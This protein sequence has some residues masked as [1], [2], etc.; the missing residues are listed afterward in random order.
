M[1][2]TIRREGN[3]SRLLSNLALAVCLSALSSCSHTESGL[4]TD[5]SASSEANQ[6]GSHSSKAATSSR[7]DS[8]RESTTATPS[9]DSPAS[10]TSARTTSSS[11]DIFE[12]RILPIFHAQRPSSC[13]ECHL[14]GVDLKNYIHPDQEKTFAALVTAGLIDVEKPNESKI[15]TFISRKPEKPN[16]ITDDIRRQEFEGFRAWIQAAVNEPTLLAAKTQDVLGPTVP[17]EVIRHARRD[18]V[19]ASFLDNI[20]AE[21]GRCSSCH[22]PDQNEKQV[23][24]HGEQVSWIK[25]RDPQATLDYMIEA[26]LINSESPEESLLLLKPTMQVE[27]GGGQKMMI[28]DRTYRQFRRFIDDYAA[29]VAGKYE[30]ADSLP[31]QSEEVSVATSMTD[32]IWFKLEGVPAQYDKKLLQVDVYRREGQ[33]WSEARWA[34]ADRAVAGN[35]QL[36]QQTLSL[37]AARGSQRAEEIRGSARLPAGEYLVKV[38]VDVDGKLSK[39]SQTGLGEHELVGEVVVN[40][41]WRRGYGKMTIARCPPDEPARD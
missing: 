39:D 22:S 38:Y 1:W 13:A 2:S 14:G 10:D 23:K 6:D 18:R 37:T 32:G 29:M 24:E 34:T 4:L 9:D 17:V 41:Q 20:W 31:Q 7:E 12:K 5:A 30:S 36:W 21:V 11:L 35:Q 27:H 3:V 15:L 8:G 33:G 26:D 25:L 19:L 28:G 40:S 16:L